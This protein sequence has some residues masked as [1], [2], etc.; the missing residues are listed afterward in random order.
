MKKEIDYKQLPVILKRCFFI[1]GESV[2]KERIFFKTPRFLLYF[3]ACPFSC[4]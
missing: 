1:L 2:H 4:R 3:P